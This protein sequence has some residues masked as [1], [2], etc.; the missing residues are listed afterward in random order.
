MALAA[1]TEWDVRTTGNDANGGGFDTASTGTDGSQGAVI[2]AYTDLVISGAT[3]HLA[4]VARAF[5]STDVGNIVNIPTTGGGFTAGRYQV[6]SVSAGIATM[7]RVVGTLASTGGSGN[8]GGSLLTVDVITKNTAVFV[9]GNTLHIK[10]GTYTLTATWIIDTSN[11]SGNLTITGYQTTH[12]DGGTRPLITTATNTTKLIQ[13]GAAIY[14]INNINFSNTAGTRADGIWFAGTSTGPEINGAIFD[15][16]AVALNGDNGVGGAAGFVLVNV[17][18]KNCTSDGV[19]HWFRSWVHGC[20]FHSNGGSGIIGETSSQPL[21]MTNTLCVKNTG[22]GATINNGGELFA[23]NCDFSDNTGDGVSS[24][25]QA[26][27]LVL[28][29]CT[30]YGNGGWGVNVAVTGLNSAHFVSGRY[31]AYGSNASGNRRNNTF[32]Q[33]NDIVLTADPYTNSTG[34]DYSKNGTAGGGAALKAAGWPGMFP[35][36]LST[37]VIDVGAVGSGTGGGGG[38]TTYILSQTIVQYIGEET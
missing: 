6:V 21:N 15:G 32:N 27:T 14:T 4:S 33:S 16:F 7:D 1:T 11:N 9:G 2:F 31:N 23:I 25:N 18:V 37:G 26:V 19:R 10:A 3:N 12:N 38:S 35:G 34:G 30:I 17:E 36:G 13:M 24:T 29:N 28:N 5:V 8:L 22:A 20:Y